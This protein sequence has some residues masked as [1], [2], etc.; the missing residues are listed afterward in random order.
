MELHGFIE[1]K[2]TVDSGWAAHALVDLPLD[3]SFLA[4]LG[5]SRVYKSRPL[6]SDDVHG[7]CPE[8]VELITANAPV[9]LFKADYSSL[10]D[11]KTM[12]ET[13]DLSFESLA[14]QTFVN[15]SKL[16]CFLSICSLAELLRDTLKG[17]TDA[18]LVVMVVGYE[19]KP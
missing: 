1:T 2:L 5:L 11:L 14:Y 13:T 8:L 3:E 18:R 4:L 9:I 10:D 7:V 19:K 17:F 15:V 16:P 6:L 12:A